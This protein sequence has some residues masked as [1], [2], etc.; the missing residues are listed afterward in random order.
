MCLCVP[1]LPVWLRRGEQLLTM[2]PLSLWCL[3]CHHGLLS[4]SLISRKMHIADISPVS[5]V[6]KKTQY[7]IHKSFHLCFFATKTWVFFFFLI[8]LS[9]EGYWGQSPHIML[10][11]CS[12]KTT[13][14]LR[15]AQLNE[16]EPLPAEARCHLFWP[17]LW[18]FPCRCQCWLQ[19]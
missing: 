3:V 16:Q 15:S 4:F 14:A 8:F 19:W 18:L 11:L 17:D 12:L 2:L 9:G 13:V 5:A 1:L 7:W 10:R 6:K